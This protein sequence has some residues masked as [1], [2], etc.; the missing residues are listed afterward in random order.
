MAPVIKD[1]R[2]CTGAQLVDLS[3][4]GESGALP[5]QKVCPKVLK[6]MSFFG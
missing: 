6:S 2:G 5:F 4:R 1:L 3:G